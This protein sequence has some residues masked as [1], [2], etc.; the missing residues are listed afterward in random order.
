M[1]F[2]KFAALTVT[3]AIELGDEIPGA[4]DA[5]RAAWNAVEVTPSSI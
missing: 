3:A 1:T 5:V 4:V 2:S